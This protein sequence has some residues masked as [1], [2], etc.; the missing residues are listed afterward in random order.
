MCVIVGLARPSDKPCRL[1][2]ET[3]QSTSTSINAYLSAGSPD[4]IVRPSAKPLNGFPEAVAGSQ[5]K[6]GGNFM[7]TPQQRE[8]LLAATPAAGTMLRRFYS[9]EDLLHSIERYTLWIDDDHL[10][11]ARSIPE[12]AV[13]LDKIRADREKGGQDKTKVA[14]TPHRYARNAHKVLHALLIPSV[15]SERRPYLQAAL[16]GPDDI[17]GHTLVVV[18]DPPAHLFALISSRMHR[19]WAQA[20]GGRMKSDLRYSSSVVYNTFPVPA[21]SDAQKRSL[22]DHSRNIIRTRGRHVGMAL[23]DLYNPESMPPDLLAAHQENDEYLE[24]SIYGRAFADDAQRL[25]RLFAM[26]ARG[27]ERA[28][29]DG[30]LFAAE[31]VA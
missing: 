25:E 26:Y 5:P 31:V 11:F 30:T 18:Y 1:F 17:V 4:V 29:R 28:A 8:R 20:V 13:R 3:Y 21:L 19:I 7:L 15:S 10:A 9:A 24:K 23:A 27:R 16:V 22:G 12:I 14:A 6:D 2:G